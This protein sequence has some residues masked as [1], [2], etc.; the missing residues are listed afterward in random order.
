MSWNSGGCQDSPPKPLSPRLCSQLTSKSLETANNLLTNNFSPNSDH[1]SADIFNLVKEVETIKL[2]FQNDQELFNEADCVSQSLSTLLSQS[3]KSSSSDTHESCSQLIIQASSHSSTLTKN[4]SIKPKL[5]LKY[6]STDLGPFIIIIESKSTKNIGNIHPMNLGKKLASMN[7]KGIKDICKKGKRRISIEFDNPDRANLFLVDNP[8]NNDSDMD[9]FIPSRM[10]SSKGVIRNVGSEITTDDILNSAVSIVK[11]LD[12]RPLNRRVFENGTVTYVPSTTWL[13]TF[14]G[15]NLPDKIA[16]WGCIR[17][18]NLY[19]GPVVQCHNCL[20]YGHTK[21]NCHSNNKRCRNCGGNHDEG[22]CP[23]KLN[24]KCVFCSGDHVSTDRSCPEHNRQ[25]Q[26]NKII[27]L[28]NISYFEAVKMVPKIYDENLN[29]PHP[30]STSSQDLRPQGFPRLP[31]KNNKNDSN[32]ISV[33]NRR[34]ILPSKPS[35]TTSYSSILKR[36]KIIQTQSYDRDSH[37]SELFRFSLPLS[38]IINNQ[39]PHFSSP[40]RSNQSYPSSVP[41]L[42][43]A[44]ILTLIKSYIEK[45]VNT[46]FSKSLSAIINKKSISQSEK[47]HSFSPLPKSP[48]P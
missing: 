43:E 4:S 18:V 37:E 16:L 21:P 5:S 14:Q 10:V 44:E 19:I 42:T 33:S 31:S 25:R 12:A 11:I 46:E 39:V 29:V 17:N 13:L 2:L 35:S 27:A 3:P 36:K 40:P 45:N 9:V 28:E 32:I 30:S 7:I 34:L 6:S 26:I 48:T 41:S 23:N 15:K 38:P 8:F 24:P 22:V 47:P 1:F 20:R